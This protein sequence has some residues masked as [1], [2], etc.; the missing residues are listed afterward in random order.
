MKSAPPNGA[1]IVIEDLP[2]L[3]HLTEEEMAR[4]FG[5]GKHNRARL[6]VEVLEGRELMASNLTASMT[7]GVLRIEG[8]NNADHIRILQSGDQIAVEGISIQAGGASQASVSAA[9]VQRIAV[10]ALAG[11]D[12][13]WI[14]DGSGTPTPVLELAGSAGHDVLHSKGTTWSSGQ[15]DDVQKVFQWKHAIYALHADGWVSV[16]GEKVW[17]NTRD[18]LMAD[19]G[20]LIR[21]GTDSTLWRITQGGPDWV[22]LGDGFTKFHL[23]AGGTVV[24]VGHN[25]YLG[26][27]TV[28]G[29]WQ[30]VL[31][32][33]QM[34][35]VEMAAG[36]TVVAVG[37]NGWL[38]R[39]TVSGGWQQL[40]TDA[41]QFAVDGFGAVY[42]LRTTGE[43]FHHLG[44]VNNYRQLGS[45]GVTTADGAIWFLAADTAANHAIHRIADG[46]LTPTGGA[47]VDLAVGP[48]GAARA[49]TDA[50]NVFRWNGSAWEMV[51][52]GGIHAGGSFWFLHS[53]E[54]DGAGNHAIYRFGGGQV[55]A[56]GGFAQVLTVGVDGRA[57]A[58]TSAN[59]VF[60][61][62]GSQ[63]ALVA[64][65]LGRPTG[66]AF[67]A[68]DGW[69][70]Q[71]FQNGGI[72]VNGGQVIV[73][74]DKNVWQRYLSLGLEGGALG[75]PITNG[76][77]FG[78]WWGHQFE[79]GHLSSNGS[80]TR[81]VYRNGR[82]LRIEGSDTAETIEVAPHAAAFSQAHVVRLGGTIVYSFNVSQFD[83]IM[84]EAHGGAD[85]VTISQDLNLPARL[86]GGAGNDTL[87]GGGGADSL[88]GQGDNDELDG[89][90]S[91]DI[92]SGGAGIDA[93]YLSQARETVTD[94][95]AV[96]ISLPDGNPQSRNTCGPNSAWRV[97]QAYGSPVT[98]Q[99]LIDSASEGS[100]VSRWNLGTT[101]ATL[102]NA[103]NSHLRGL[104]DYRFSLV[105]R[106]SVDRVIDFLKQGR[107]VVAQIR[108]SGKEVYEI[109][110]A[111]GGV[112]GSIPGIGGIT[113]YEIPALHWVA[114]DGFDS[115]QRLIYYTDTNGERCQMSYDAFNSV[116]NWNFGTA[117]NTVL[118]GLGVVPGT[119]IA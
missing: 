34:R 81:V 49:L 4:T 23:A 46:Q 31:S 64:N 40:H 26:Y 98:I 7:G 17:A 117:Q 54:T 97:M 111:I 29:G 105:T 100:V 19:D 2:A 15:A 108:V 66:D 70:A 27:W 63:W 89:G 36:G 112:L 92:M 45:H 8:T 48:D 104:G 6:G 22:K 24:A 43:V 96:G 38:G 95:E 102:V 30:Q 107:P 113:R 67:E 9:A 53:A 65:G 41:R 35:Q 88:Y 76:I 75:R 1:R 106:S 56:T 118:Q 115:S 119:F 68:G 16:N 14:G 10:E 93:A 73:I 116:F 79:N 110:G 60:R 58:V 83:E 71:H 80:Q 86:Y 90:D 109:G 55:T 5:A 33:G 69:R 44:G 78:G 82:S 57:W 18:F 74:G 101:G 47:A 85:R 114:V 3:E 77:N 13:V 62:N 59:N 99:Q 11:D 84:V 37:H 87:I 91:A 12:H 72:Y 52:S 50:H 94:C 25:A 39:W 61:W 28:G 20:A 103:M 42:A 51:A 21:L 32:G